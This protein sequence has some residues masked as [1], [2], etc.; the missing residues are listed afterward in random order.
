MCLMV[1]HYILKTHSDG[2]Y[3]S[4]N[5]IYIYSIKN[6]KNVRD[7]LSLLS[8]TLFGCRYS[9]EVFWKC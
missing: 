6:V 5:I 2:T 3:N 7:E 9:T 8:I 4:M 1:F